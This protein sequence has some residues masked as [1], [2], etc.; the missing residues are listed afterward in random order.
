M[1][2]Y[3]IEHLKNSFAA[4]DQFLDT[5]AIQ[6]ELEKIQDI[7]WAFTGTDS[8]PSFTIY[9]DNCTIWIIKPNGQFSGDLTSWFGKPTQVIASNGSK[10]LNSCISVLIMVNRDGLEV[11]MLS[12]EALSL[13]SILLKAR[14]KLAES[15]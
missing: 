7:T 13:K 12:L 9:H 6:L 2:K 5:L 15:P 3:S 11:S 1:D 4:L 10:K 14:I 8:D